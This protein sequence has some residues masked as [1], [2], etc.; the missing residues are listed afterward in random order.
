MGCFGATGI[1]ARAL[2]G[3]TLPALAVTLAVGIAAFAAALYL[4]RAP[5]Q[6]AG[7]FAALRARAVP[8]RRASPAGRRPRQRGDCCHGR[9]D[10]GA[11]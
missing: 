5:L 4:A 1:A 8:L 6:L 9:Q 2:M 11:H 3:E 7:M 10:S